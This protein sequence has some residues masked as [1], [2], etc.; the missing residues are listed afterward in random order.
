MALKESIVCQVMIM[1]SWIHTLLVY[2]Y[3][4]YRFVESIDINV[5]DPVAHKHIPYVVILI[6]MA[7]EWAQNHGGALPSTR[8]EKLEF[9]VW[10]LPT[11]FL[12]FTLDKFIPILVNAI[13]C[14]I[15]NGYFLM[16]LV[17]VYVLESS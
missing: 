1:N 7:D 10:Y 17:F 8:E 12:G 5:P 14:N 6:K 11:F 13:K 15:N 2:R 3:C 4:G 9:K 16:D